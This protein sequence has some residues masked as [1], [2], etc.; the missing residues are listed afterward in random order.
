MRIYD[1]NVLLCL[2]IETVRA[3]SFFL[4]NMCMVE[5]VKLNVCESVN[6]KKICSR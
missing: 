2:V 4:K 5:F 1:L 3:D 6:T